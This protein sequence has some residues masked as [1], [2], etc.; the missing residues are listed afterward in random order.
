MIIKKKNKKKI[1][2][3]SFSF[4]NCKNIETFEGHYFHNYIYIITELMMSQVRVRERWRWTVPPPTV[5]P[6]GPN[7]ISCTNK[8]YYATLNKLFHSRLLILSHFVRKPEFCLCENNG[9]DQLC[10]YCTADEHLCFCSQI[11]PP[12]P[13]STY[14]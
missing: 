14:I 5:R 2:S 11:V 1:M 3:F 7:M 4:F 10:S 13:S 12:Y 8:R 6:Q 9:T